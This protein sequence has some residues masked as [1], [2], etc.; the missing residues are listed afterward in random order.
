MLFCVLSILHMFADDTF[1]FF[2]GGDLDNLSLR[3]L[4]LCF[5]AVSGLKVNLAKLELVLV[6]KLD[7]VVG[8]TGILGY[9]VSFLPIKYLSFL[10]EASYEAKSFCNSVAEKI[11]R[12]F[13]SWKMMYLP[14]VVGLP[15]SRSS[16]SIC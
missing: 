13:A 6:D 8:L 1:P 14:R 2:W 11:K 15:L 5:E 12:Q 16:F 7:S 9:N 3:V 10:L 4:F